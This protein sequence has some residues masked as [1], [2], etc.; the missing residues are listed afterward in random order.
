MS[1]KPVARLSNDLYMLFR[2]LLLRRSGLFYPE[3]KREDLEHGLILAMKACGART[4]DDLYG[5]ALSDETVWEAI[6]IHLTIGE[7]SFFRNKPQFD[8]LRNEIV[9]DLLERRSM[10]HNLRIWSAGCATG[11]EPYSL[12]ILLSETIP[13]LSEWHI[14]I[15]AT[16]INPNFL[17]RARQALYGNWSFREISEAIKTRYFTPEQN[18][19]RLKPEIRS[20]V[21]FNRLN[22]IEPVYPSIITGTS[23]LDMIIC[24]NVTIYFDEQTT[25]QIVNR[26]YHALSPGGWLIVGHSEP[27][28][29]MYQ[30]FEVY[31]FPNTVIYRKRLDAP[32]FSFTAD[33]SNTL[34]GSS[35]NG[36]A[37][38]QEPSPFAVRS[39]PGDPPRKAPPMSPAF[40]APA[41][42]ALPAPPVPSTPP[43]SPQVQP[44]TKTRSKPS[45]QD[46]PQPPSSLSPGEL[47]RKITTML[48]QGNKT[49]AEQL[50][51]TLLLI[52]PDH[53]EALTT[54]GRLYADRGEWA[55][56]Q[57]HCENAIE[58]NPLHTEA[59]YILAQ[60]YEHEGQYDAALTEYRRVV[61]L[62]RNH[63]M[64]MLGM[65][66]V[67]RQIGRAEDARRSYRNVLKQLGNLPPLA[68]VPNAE[69]ATA[70]ELAAFVTRQIQLLG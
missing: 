9:P 39:A 1:G 66:N 57:Y 45:P 28:S 46:P 32:L 29:T 49:G 27:Q 24:R 58:Y 16:D 44:K 59:H 40:F 50:L 48:A 53:V 25:R 14:T 54:L 6:L 2:D 65:A 70:S 61:F 18:R 8:A 5:Q 3:H 64:G 55:C 43:S 38:H 30:Q 19:W 31:N 35:R 36:E 10:L 20:M 42:A 7:T 26:F 12:A 13:N 52:Q 41:P 62:E 47:W 34:Q 11:E 15:L 37:T 69:G 33:A 56:A 68:E 23:A 17:E 4:F 67:W 63:I 60:L 21:L 22:L 51:N